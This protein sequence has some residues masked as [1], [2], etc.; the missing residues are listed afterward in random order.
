MN[1]SLYDKRDFTDVIKLGSQDFSGIIWVEP[2]FK[3][4]EGDLTIEGGNVTMEAGGWSDMSQRMQQTPE[5]GKA[6]KQSF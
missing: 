4:A 3:E 2:T 5:A 6:R 1:V